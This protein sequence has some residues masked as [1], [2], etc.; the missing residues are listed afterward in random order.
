VMDVCVCVC[1]CL[2]VCV[3]VCVFVCFLPEHGS[4]GLVK[5]GHCCE[6]ALVGDEV[7]EDCVCVC[8]CVCIDT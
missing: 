3:C 2:S 1:V 4:D 7:V 5:A 8:V 6:V